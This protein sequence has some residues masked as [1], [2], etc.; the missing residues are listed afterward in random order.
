MVWEATVLGTLPTMMIESPSSR[1][2]N[3]SSLAFLRMSPSPLSLLREMVLTSL[4]TSQ[5]WMVHLTAQVMVPR[6]SMLQAMPNP[7]LSILKAILSEE[8]SPLHSV[9][10]Q[11]KS[12]KLSSIPRSWKHSLPTTI[13]GTSMNGYKLVTMFLLLARPN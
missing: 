12:L 1:V 4:V 5:K 7:S 13:L 2:C 8:T 6:V 10:P 9:K 11:R 3:S